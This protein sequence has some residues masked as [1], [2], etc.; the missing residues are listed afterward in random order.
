MMCKKASEKSEVITLSRHV[1]FHMCGR[2]TA[3]KTGGSQQ[4]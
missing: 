4:A 3:I 2:I 1:E